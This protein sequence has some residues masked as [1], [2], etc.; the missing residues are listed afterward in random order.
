MKKTQQES[1]KFQTH[2]KEPKWQVIVSV[3]VVIVLIGIEVLFL[4]KLL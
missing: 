4:L 1:N 2:I 3:V